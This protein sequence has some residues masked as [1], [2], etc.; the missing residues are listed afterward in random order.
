ML[1]NY[2]FSKMANIS[3]ARTGKLEYIGT[4]TEWK[5][6]GLYSTNP[7]AIG[8]VTHSRFR[9][10]PFHV[11]AQT[12]RLAMSQDQ[13][14]LAI[15]AKKPNGDM[16]VEI[17]KLLKNGKILNSFKPSTFTM[18]GIDKV[19]AL[20]VANVNRSFIMAVRKGNGIQFIPQYNDGSAVV[21]INTDIAPIAMAVGQSTHGLVVGASD[22][23][24]YSLSALGD[25]LYKIS[26]SGVESIAL[27]LGSGGTYSNRL[28]LEKKTIVDG[29][30]STDFIVLYTTDSLGNLS[31]VF[32][33]PL[34]NTN[35][36]ACGYEQNQVEIPFSDVRMVYLSETD[37]RLYVQVGSQMLI[38][39]KT[40]SNRFLLWKTVA[41]ATPLPILDVPFTDLMV[42]ASGTEYLYPQSPTLVLVRNQDNTIV[43]KTMTVVGGDYGV[44]GTRPVSYS[45]IVC[46]DTSNQFYQ[47]CVPDKHY[48]DIGKRAFIY[49]AQVNTKEYKLMAD[50]NL[51][52][53]TINWSDI[54]GKPQSTVMAIDDAVA[55]RH[56]HANLAY[57]NKITEDISGQMLYGNKGLKSRALADW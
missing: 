8:D 46:H 16:S 2:S 15:A 54:Q 12:S 51:T 6:A 47:I 25:T 28:S 29:A 11:D 22:D 14:V 10:L 56:T 39:T 38:F 34:T 23:V 13:N 45:N 26:Q 48:P 1:S 44:G 21:S 3:I 35:H 37:N 7:K 41:V 17:C 18:S 53:T 55:K 49:T 5:N 20:A 30:T 31:V 4:A 33:N 43:S 40:A 36:I 24:G 9:T 32:H 50:S 27:P 57:L 19:E 52:S 42:N